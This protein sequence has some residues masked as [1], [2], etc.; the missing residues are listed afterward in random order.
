[1]LWHDRSL[2]VLN[3]V[4]VAVFTMGIIKYYIIQ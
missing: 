3:A 4:A 1:M 2:I